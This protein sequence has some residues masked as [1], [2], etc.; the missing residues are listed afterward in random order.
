MAATHRHF[1]QIGSRLLIFTL[2]QNQNYHPLKSTHT[3][4]LIIFTRN[5]ELGKC[6]T[7]LAKT[8]G[9]DAALRIYTFLLKHTAKVTSQVKDTDLRVYYSD[10][11]GENDI[12][13]A[14]RY[15]KHLQQGAD[16]GARMENAFS[17]TFEAGY[18]KVLI[19]GSDLYD[20]QESDIQESFEALNTCE[21]VIGP[22]S[23]GGYYLLGLKKVIPSLFKGKH[24][25]T[26][27]VL[28]ATLKDLEP[29]TTCFLPEKNDIDRFED[30][31]GNP[32]FEALLTP[33]SN[34]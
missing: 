2:Y 34:D 32:V 3:Q 27:E 23:D 17:E 7:R 16:L 5:P 19:I 4:A 1:L 8:I 26:P 21:T 9:D 25:G 20:L 15:G 24:W 13:D 14:T 30:I 10:Y 18:N 33:Y 22:A 12:W 28:P 11:I 31:A 6:K 29:F